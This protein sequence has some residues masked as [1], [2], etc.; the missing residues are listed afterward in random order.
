MASELHAMAAFYRENRAFVRTD[1]IS[2]VEDDARDASEV[3][4]SLAQLR[5]DF[6]DLQTSSDFVVVRR[7]IW[8]C[9]NPAV[10]AVLEAWLHERHS[11]DGQGT[12]VALV[13]TLASTNFLFS[14]DEIEA[15]ARW[16]G[17]KEIFCLSAAS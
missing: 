3:L 1:L 8:V 7:S 17:F 6:R 5:R 15:V 9:E 13:P 11:R 10:W 4:Q 2:I 12:E 16:E 14:D